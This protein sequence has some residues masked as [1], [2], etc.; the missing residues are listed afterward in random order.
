LHASQ[1]VILKTEKQISIKQKPYN[2]RELYDRYSGMLLGYIF[3][4][5]KD[6]K[7]AEQHLINIYSYLPN[8]IN[9]LTSDGINTWCQLQRLAK[10]Y[11]E[12][13]DSTQ[14]N[15]QLDGSDL[16]VN[17]GHNRYLVLMTFEQKQVFYNVYYYGKTTAQLAQELNK[18]SGYSGI[19][20]KWGT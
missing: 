15:G 7:L 12:L 19:H 9:E 17:N 8:H 10:R 16:S 13:A 6:N 2:L 5:V 3:E 4:I 11:L 14:Y 1:A 18:D 20:R